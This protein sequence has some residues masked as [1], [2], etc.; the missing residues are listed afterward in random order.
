MTNSTDFIRIQAIELEQLL[1]GSSDNP[2]LAA[3]LKQRLKSIEDL[4]TATERQ[5]GELLP[6]EAIVLPRTA[7]FLRGGGVD[8]TRGIRPSL[9]G[10]A[11][12]Q[13]DKMFT[14]QALHDEREAAR[15]SGR[16]RRP[17]G[18]STPGLLFTGTPRGSFGLEFVPLDSPDLTVRDVH[19]QS[20]HNVANAIL[21]VADEA[22]RSVEDLVRGI[23][24][25]VLQPMKQFLKVL[26]AH[27]AELKFAFSDSSAS[28]LTASQIQSASARLQRELKEEEVDVKGVFRGLTRESGHFD[29]L[30]EDNG[31]ITGVVADDLTEDDLERIDLLT[32]HAC[33]ATVL[34][35]TFSNVSGSPRQTYLLINAREDG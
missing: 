26:A 23:P 31:L 12:L 29:L 21:R 6:R 33:V 34:K 13:Y 27:E 4:I 15:T 7:V 18:A 24:P 19:A 10:E 25:R 1:A 14:E 22:V 16:H 2:I 30:S 35:T 3:Q 5:P 20:L 11:L 28:S 9:A 8:G 32:N 17:R